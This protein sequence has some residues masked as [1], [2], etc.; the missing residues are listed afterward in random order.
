[1]NYSTNNIF[2][3]FKRIN[4]KY[5][6]LNKFYICITNNEKTEFKEIDINSMTDKDYIKITPF[7]E[8]EDLYI[9][10]ENKYINDILLKKEYIDLILITNISFT[11]NEINMDMDYLLK[12]FIKNDSNIDDKILEDIYY[13]KNFSKKIKLNLPK[14][15]NYSFENKNISKKY[16]FKVN[17]IEL[18]QSFYQDDNNLFYS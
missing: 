12:K 7:S 17:L 16:L 4:D 13:N 11:L 6:A 2:R 1:M 18:N 14:K 3:E 9:S 15:Y 10:I 5:I 8:N